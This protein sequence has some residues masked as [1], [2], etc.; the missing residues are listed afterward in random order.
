MKKLVIK[1]FPFSALILSTYVVLN[2]FMATAIAEPPSK[3]YSGTLRVGVV[4]DTGVGER[5]YHP[6]FI[7]VSKALKKITLICYYILET[8][9]INQ[10]PFHKL[11]QND[12]FMR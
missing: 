6:G 4:G 9:F 1:F 8:L 5:A 11:A 12:I 3:N 2:S 10:K 7:A